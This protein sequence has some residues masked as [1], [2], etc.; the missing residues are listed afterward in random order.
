MI[1]VLSFN[2]WNL[3]GDYPARM[4]LLDEH[5]RR[6]QPDIICLQE[7]SL[8]Q[9]RLSPQIGLLSYTC[10]KY[11]S[12]YASQ[13]KWGDRE[14]GLATFSR[15][16]VV[17][18][19]SLM[20]PDSESDMQRRVQYAI[21]KS[22]DDTIIVGNTHLSYHLDTEAGRTRQCRSIV[23]HLE[24]LSGQYQCKNIILAGDFNSTPGSEPMRILLASSLGLS[25]PYLEADL[26]RKAY[27]FPSDS[28]YA[29]AAL[30]PDRWIDYI[31]L[32]GDIFATKV[33]ISLDGRNGQFASDHVALE[34]QID[35]SE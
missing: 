26:Q 13:G 10:S 31:L 9:E 30:W 11:T 20:L 6:T 16:P 33:S 29:N 25:D 27:S 24:R 17:G 7:I 4:K 34:A 32:A 1:K 35:F 8:E 14:E 19:E 5:I 23:Q 18:F 21:L 3:N 22:G 15:L 28:P 2:T 12:L